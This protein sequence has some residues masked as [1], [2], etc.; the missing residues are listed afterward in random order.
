MH[1]RLRCQAHCSGAEDHSAASPVC[2]RKK[3]VEALETSVL[4]NPSFF[5]AIDQ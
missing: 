1:L 5:E 2:H 4:G 3:P